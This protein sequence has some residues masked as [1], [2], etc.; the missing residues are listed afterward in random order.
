MTSRAFVQGTPPLALNVAAAKRPCG[1]V[2]S[3]HSE[4]LIMRAVQSHQGGKPAVNPRRDGNDV[5][6][7]KGW[8][9]ASADSLSTR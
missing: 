4:W 6:S 7:G 1:V 5:P 9:V 2:V 3:S 8:A